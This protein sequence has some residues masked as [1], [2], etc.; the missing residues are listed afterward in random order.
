MGRIFGWRALLVCG[1]ASAFMVFG[2]SGALAD[3]FHGIAFAKQCTSPVKI[4]D[5]YTCSVQILN[6]VDTAG[7]TLRVTGFS[8]VVHSAGGN[9]ATANIMPSTGL[10]FT[11]PVVCSGGTGTGTDADP[12]IGATQCLLPFGASITTKPFS[13][14]TV[15]PGDFNLTNHQ[16][17]D[18]ATLNWNNTCT[19]P[20]PNCTTDT[21]EITAGSSAIVQL[22]T[23]TATSIHNAGH[24]AVTAVEIGSTVHDFVTVT[25]A[26]AGNVNIDWFLNGD[27]SGAAAANSGSIGPVDANG[28][29]DATGFAFAVNT[30]GGRS[31]R[32]HYEGSGS[33]LASDGACEP[34]QV[35]D[36]NIQITP[37]GIN[38][39]GKT[40]TFTAH[41]NVNAGGG[42]ANAPDGTQISFTINSGPGAF[43]T[44]NPCTT[45]G[46]TGSCSIG[47][48]STITGS[49]FVSAH[50]TLAVSGVTLTRNTDATG[51]NSGPANK[52]W[53]D[54]TARTDILNSAG[55]VILT[56]VAGTVVHDKVFV[57]RTGG[58]PASVP[59]PSGSVVF[60]RY[61]S[62]NCSGTAVNQT[63]ALT[64]GN[65]SVAES[66]TFA[67]T[68][69]MPYQAEYLGDANYPARTGACEPLTVTPVPAPA[70]AIV[71]NPKSQ[72]LA[73]GGT[74]TFSITVTNTGNV[75]LTDVHVTDPL[76]PLCNRT[77][78][79]IAGLASMA[80]GA[81]VTYTCTRPGVRSGF[82]NVATAV[83]T[84][85]SGPDVT[86]SDTAPVT[87]KALVPKKVVKK[88][89]KVVSHK[90][91]KATG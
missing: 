83:G 54:D 32:A 26:T 79:D 21:Q 9:V 27:C 41:V 20:S 11:G 35:V 37:N 39:I 3:D 85:P 45:T 75:V 87:V 48:S 38:P 65:P 59:N 49:T 30:T 70:I 14:Y 91:P 22:P 62:L 1:V 7:D 2:V 10:V 29:L 24:Q 42:F 63:V 4:G 71:K 12:Y 66:D 53:A 15:Q 8:D 68:A 86:A 58:T 44:S 90:K 76:S 55:T 82:D 5:P 51:A 74:A 81:A 6:V 25:G 84:P 56:A 19:A 23:T 67:V 61:A 16:L 88:K 18:T 13:H 80:P 77:K 47:L 60:H 34:L 64:A 69:D 57:S 17:T 28:Q 89:P 73:V 33:V 72:S 31:F 40:H 43:T 36:A 78:A 46:G 50:A 52:S